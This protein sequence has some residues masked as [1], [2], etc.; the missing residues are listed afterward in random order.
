VKEHL[1]HQCLVTARTLAPTGNVCVLPRGHEGLHRTW[2]GLP[3]QNGLDG[4]KYANVEAEI[5]KLCRC[6]EH[7]RYAAAK[8]PRNACETCWR[9]WM[10]LH[11]SLEIETR[12]MR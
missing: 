9:L 3:F 5:V 11:P 6:P 12:W 4:R 7:K 8:P 2:A 1:A 10:L